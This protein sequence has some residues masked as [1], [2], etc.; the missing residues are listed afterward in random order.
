MPIYRV[1][2]QYS[3]LGQPMENVLWYRDGGSTVGLDPVVACAEL[4]ERVRDNIVI[5]Q[6]GQTRLM[7]IWPRG[8]QAEVVE[9]SY[10][11]APNLDPLLSAPVL[12]N[13]GAAVSALNAAAY[14]PEAA[15]I[16]RLNCGIGT[17][18]PLDYTPRRGYFCF[19]P[20][21]EDATLENGQIAAGFATA[22]ANFSAALLATQDIGG[23]FTAV[24]IR[25]GRG[26]NGVGTLVNGFSDIVSASVR[27]DATWRR[28]RS[29][30]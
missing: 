22:L 30:S 7:D 1:N 16:I 21:A 15:A 4:G 25:V 2:V 11:S 24:P 6:A 20:L 18:N 13:I 3:F 19:G 23:G 5:S 27:S 26:R 17:V 10:L 8:V 14:A 12:T 28:S 29:G 9:V